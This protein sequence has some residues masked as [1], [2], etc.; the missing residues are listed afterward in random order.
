MIR[1]VQS[2]HPTWA[3]ENGIPPEVFPC[4]YCDQQIRGRRY[5]LN[6]HIR[7]FHAEEQH[8]EGTVT[9]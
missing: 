7:E 2:D 5:N 8:I 6:R 3:E 9:Q 4:P 1:H